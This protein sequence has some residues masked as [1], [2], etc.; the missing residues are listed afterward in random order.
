MIVFLSSLKTFLSSYTV[1]IKKKDENIKFVKAG[2]KLTK[3]KKS[4]FLGLLHSAPDWRVLCDLND[5]L[6][7]P[8]FLAV[9]QLR[10]DMLI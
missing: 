3:T 4:P 1:S 6:V 5:K 8:P 9:P 7:I 10:P 2:A